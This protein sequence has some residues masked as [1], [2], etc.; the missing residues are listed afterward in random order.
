MD[1][2]AECIDLA[3]GDRAPA[4]MGPVEFVRRFRRDQLSVLSPEA[5]TRPIIYRRLM[6]LHSIFI[7]RPE[8]IERVLLT[9]VVN[10]IKSPLRRRIL[11][12][13]VGSGLLV[14]EGDFWRRQRRIAAPAFHHKRI[15]GFVDTM[16]GCA[17]EWSE[18]WTHGAEF[19]LA[20]ALLH[21]TLD[22]IART[23]FSV[24]VR[25]AVSE[26]HRLLEIVLA[27][28]RP[29]ALD[30]F[31]F[32]ETL[33]RRM[34]RAYRSA[35][36][37]LDAVVEQFLAPR[38]ADG[39]DRGDLLSMLLAARDPE[40]GEGMDPMQLRDEVKTIFLA[41]HETVSNALTWTWYLLAL[42]PE[43]RDK[44]EAEVDRVLGGKPLV[45]EQLALLPYSRRVIEESMRLYPPAH[46]MSRTAVGPDR[47]D[48]VEVPA[49]AIITICPH[50][51]HRNPALWPEPERFDPD[52]FAPDRAQGRHRFA[53]LPFGGGPR[54]CIGH[55]YATVETLAILATVTQRWRLDLVPG[56]PVEP[57]GSITLRPASGLWVT[58]TRRANHV[59]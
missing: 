28:A 51:T 14:S 35:L 33:P 26:V 22:I 41:G 24:D 21:V 6:F 47:F 43:V 34:P 38:V 3:R 8:Y 19:D 13:L 56:R 18:A 23:M 40:T 48:E 2:S 46:T 54:I 4:R 44:V 12:P 39:K 50:A 9:N 7:N 42:H 53:Y 27:Y 49:G 58:A 25:G 57:I 5:Y 31:G 36:A 16:A 10:Y 1:A 55:S 29:S 59:A 15:A 11:G 45:F 52:R 17:R 30:L 20:A 32:P 37:E